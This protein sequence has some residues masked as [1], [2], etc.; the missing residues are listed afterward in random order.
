MTTQKGAIPAL[1]LTVPAAPRTW[2][3]LGG[4][5]GLY[6]VDYAVPLD[7]LGVT[8]EQAR[9]WSK[10]ANVPLVLE[11]ATQ[12]DA[13]AATTAYRD[14]TGE[15]AQ[16]TALAAA[17]VETDEERN[18]VSDQIDALKGKDAGRVQDTPDPPEEG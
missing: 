10:A 11:Q 15:A 6:H 14:A 5:P 16:A 3:F 12:A 2:H 13:D 7:T 1:R 8:D 9:K 4:I 17:L 18:R